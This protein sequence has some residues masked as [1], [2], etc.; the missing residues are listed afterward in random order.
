MAGG[1][2]GA[3]V[4]G[5]ERERWGRGDRFIMCLRRYVNRF[6]V[7]ALT[8]CPIFLAPDDLCRR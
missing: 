5:R 6:P 2:W 3:G 7:A 1:V 8:S 4:A